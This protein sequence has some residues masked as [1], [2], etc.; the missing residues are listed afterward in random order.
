MESRVYAEDPYRNFLPS[1]GQ[2]TR[3]ASCAEGY[4]SV[5]DVESGADGQGTGEDVGGLASMYDG[6][7]PSDGVRCDRSVV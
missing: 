6:V 1:T 4:P 3:Y 2:L 5:E 7:A